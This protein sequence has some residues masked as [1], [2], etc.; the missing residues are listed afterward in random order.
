MDDQYQDDGQAQAQAEAEAAAEEEAQA[1]AEH[2]QALSDEAEE[3]AKTEEATNPKTTQDLQREQAFERLFKHLSAP[4]LKGFR[5][6]LGKLLEEA[7]TDGRREAEEELF[8]KGQQQAHAEWAGVFAEQGKRADKSA[9]D[10]KVRDGLVY[11]L[12]AN[13]H[14]AKDRIAEVQARIDGDEKTE[15]KLAKKRESADE[16]KKELDQT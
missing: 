8:L 5:E 2:E 15:R 13:Y 6:E 11:I 7:T 3:L 10:K 16:Y 14:K 4:P 12:H 1:Q 9:K